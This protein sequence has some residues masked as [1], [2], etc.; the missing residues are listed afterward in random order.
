MPLNDFLLNNL[1][2]PL[3]LLPKGS[4]LV[5]GAV[6][7]ALL[8]RERDYLDLDFVT[9]HSAIAIAQKI[10]SLYK[11]GFVV[12]DQERNIARVVFEGATIDIAQQE[13]ESLW[14]DLSRRDYTINAIAYDCF[15]EKLIDPLNGAQDLKQRIMRM[16]SKDNLRDDPLR[17]L[18]GYRQACQL[19]FKIEEPT[20]TTIKEL[21]PFLPQ[22][23]EERINHELGY[24]LSH[25]R[26]SFWLQEAFQDGLL[27]ACFPHL[28]EAQI[29]LLHKIDRAIQWLEDSATCL[30]NIENSWRSLA[31]LACLTNSVPE[32]AEQE[33]INLKYS[34]QEIKAVITLLKHTSDLQ[35][36]DFASNLRSQYFFFKSVGQIFPTLAIFALAHNIEEELIV[37]LVDRYCNDQDQVAHPQP[38]L[39]GNDLMMALQISPSPLIGELLTEIHLAYIEEKISNQEEAIAWIEK[40][41]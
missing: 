12:L 41:L 7:D 14:T 32:I 2:F 9:P 27:S 29:N 15:E 33:L 28:T 13:G 30:S 40:S 3:D 36:I 22:V 34:R 10:A 38:L 37:L 16:V 1:P 20:R 19:D 17:L 6:R 21:A 26:G 5:G 31:K 23:A 8:K 11:A 18:R 39:S 25:P 4:Y 35:T 24:L